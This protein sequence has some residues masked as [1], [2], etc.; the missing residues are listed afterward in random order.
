MQDRSI[1]L[2]QLINHTPKGLRQRNDKTIKIAFDHANC[3]A[4]S[5]DCAHVAAT[6]DSART[7]SIICCATDAVVAATPHQHAVGTSIVAMQWSANGAAIV[8]C[9]DTFF[10]VFAV[11]PPPSFQLSL[12]KKVPIQQ[13]GNFS[14]SISPDS[15]F[16]TVGTGVSMGLSVFELQYRQARG[17]G[18]GAQLLLLLLLLLCACTT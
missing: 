2:W 12:L 13:M 15:R 4:L 1:N 6:L 8:T 3:I 5:P 14:L 7:L 10:N 9:G 16:V 18:T 11:A 17:G